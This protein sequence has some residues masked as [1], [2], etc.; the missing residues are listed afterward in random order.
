MKIR[1]IT[2]LPLFILAALTLQA[3]DSGPV[4][5]ADAVVTTMLQRD[6][7][8]RVALERYHGMSPL[9]P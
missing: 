1:S 6:A 2:M 5:T 8:R 4:A 3:A 9:H 7:Q